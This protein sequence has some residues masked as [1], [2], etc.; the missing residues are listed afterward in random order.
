MYNCGISLQDE[1]YHLVPAWY[2]PISILSAYDYIEIGQNE[3]GEDVTVHTGLRAVDITRLDDYA[4]ESL[5]LEED[6]F[7]DLVVEALDVYIK[8]GRRRT[9]R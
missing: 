7:A 9:K 4:A 8:Q 6:P 3:W 1:C 2:A 5:S